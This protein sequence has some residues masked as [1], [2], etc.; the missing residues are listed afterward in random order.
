MR[1]SEIFGLRKT[2][3][4]LD[5]VDIDT[6]GDTPLFIDPYFLAT[7]ED[8]WSVD[9]SR[10]IRSFFQH[11]ITLLQAG[12]I[13]SA[14]ELFSYLSE[15]NE[16]RLGLSQN[17]PQ[18]R[19]IG[20]V[21]A[22]RLFDSLLESGAVQ[23][24]VVEDLEDCRVFVSGIDKDKTS[25]MATN[26]IRGHLIQYTQAQCKVGGIPLHRDVPSGFMWDRGKRQW[27]QQHTE[28]LVVN[29]QKVLLVPKAVVSFSKR[30]SAQQ[31]HRHFVLNF[32]QNEHLR[33]NSPLVRRHRRRDGTERVWVAKKDIEKSEAPMSKGFLAKFTQ[34]HPEVFKRFKAQTSQSLGSL[35]NEEITS[36]NLNS[37]VDYLI[38][39]LKDIPRGKKHATRFHRSV[40]GILELIFYPNLTSPQ[41]E[42]EI[43]SGRKR[44]D[45]TFDNAASSGFF[46]RLHTTHATPSQF[47]FVEC[48]N[49]QN[50]VA[51]PELDQLAGRFGMNKGKFG[52]LICRGIDD[53]PTFMARCADT[54]EA[55]R[56]TIIPL[57]DDDLIRLLTS[58]K[59]GVK[60]PE[61]DLLQDRL[62]AIALH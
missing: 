1:I 13:D 45:I 36:E 12:E 5:F 54:Y 11:L 55:G 24:G 33:W 19:G 48:K 37:I 56:G 9:A 34:D 16:T 40:T 3:Y 10:T 32:L 4:E 18:G 60:R 43:D 7:R 21:E 49:Y 20:P 35:T 58:L 22:D 29:D 42:R 61:E 26:M 59:A 38:E 57:V 53:L 28:M 52:L 6:K 2:Q 17:E 51:N 31:Y 44:I 27:D 30:Y 15:P 8:P 41:I 39:E 62:R 50:D 14:R 46:Y 23:S 47:I 25:D